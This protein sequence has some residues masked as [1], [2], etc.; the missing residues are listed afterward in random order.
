MELHNLEDRLVRLKEYGKLNYE[1]EKLYAG[2]L[3]IKNP[4]EDLDAFIGLLRKDINN[5][6]F[7]KK[8]SF[9]PFS[10]PEFNDIK[11]IIIHKANIKSTEEYMEF[12]DKIQHKIK[13]QDLIN[14]AEA[15]IAQFPFF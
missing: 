9:N 15:W 6:E 14:K 5:E 7:F 2:S 13:N 8:I 4:K 12:K 10:P 3:V 11:F 1:W